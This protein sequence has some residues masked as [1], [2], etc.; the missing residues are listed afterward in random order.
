MSDNP[1][2]PLAMPGVQKLRPYEPGKP[3]EAL[4]RELGIASALKLASNENPLGPSPEALAAM[5]EVLPGVARYPDGNGF[6][7]KEALAGHHDIDPACITLGNGSNDVLELVARAFLGPGRKAVMAR[8]AFAVYWLAT[9]AAGAEPVITPPNPAQHPMM[10]LGH[11][12]E[13]MV[14]HVDG[15]TR[16]VFIANPNNPTGTWLNGEEL[17]GFIEAL[18]ENIVIVVDEAYV[19][20]ASLRPG[21]LEASRWL[22]DHPNLVI[23]RTFSKAYGLAGLRVGYA[24][25]SP[26]VAD[27]LNRVRQPFNVNSVAQAA[28]VAALRDQEHIRRSVEINDRGMEQLNAGPRGLGLGSRPPPANLLC[29]H[30]GRPAAPVCAALERQGV[31]VRPLEPYGLGEFLRITIGMEK[32]NRR[33]LQA[34]GE[35]IQEA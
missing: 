16:V 20:Y 7:L 12:L 33:L 27:L 11:D 13:S 5:A 26:G 6:A 10:P 22:A 9:Q 35:A 21:Y 8:H 14:S 25:S 15:A 24:L 23:T 3:P 29:V 19:E 4:E 34:L 30:T 18:P 1:F 2:Q 31:I 28:A 32:E 17:K